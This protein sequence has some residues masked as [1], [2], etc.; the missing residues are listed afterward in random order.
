MPTRK[1][2]KQT[3]MLNLCARRWGLVV[4][5]TRTC[6]LTLFISRHD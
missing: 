3:V 5:V 1:R 2:I 4:A 6:K